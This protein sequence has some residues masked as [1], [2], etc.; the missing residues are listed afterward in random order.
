M[1]AKKA[2]GEPKSWERTS[3]V[4]F[5]LFLQTAVLHATD[6]LLIQ[7]IF[8]VVEK[9]YKKSH[10]NIT[11]KVAFNIASEA[12]YVYILNGQKFIKIAKNSQFEEF[13]KMRHF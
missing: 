5:H 4:Q 7:G 2:A 11:E 9:E 12:S 8:K 3:K 13:L 1:Q 6:H 10:L